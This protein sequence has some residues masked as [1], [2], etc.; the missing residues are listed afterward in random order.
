MTLAIPENF[1]DTLSAEIKLDAT[2][3]DLLLTA[4]TWLCVYYK[5]LS[6]NTHIPI[7][8]GTRFEAWAM[9]EMICLLYDAPGFPIHQVRKSVPMPRNFFNSA[10]ALKKRLEPKQLAGDM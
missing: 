5:N 2:E 3:K 6:P 1:I 4:Q 9:L 8:Q 7:Q 10:C